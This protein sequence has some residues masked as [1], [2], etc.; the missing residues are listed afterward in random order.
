M[1]AREIRLDFVFWNTLEVAD[2]TF[3]DLCGCEAAIL[4]QGYAAS[5]A[6]DH[7]SS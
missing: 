2:E 6:S 1:L 3:R 7:D 4:V 5:A